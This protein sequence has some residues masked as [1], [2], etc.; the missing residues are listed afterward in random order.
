[1]TRVT[2][3]SDQ[4]S[5]QVSGQI[6]GMC[7][8]TGNTITGIDHVRQC[9]TRIIL[10]RIGT[11]TQRRAFGSD[12][13]KFVSAAGNEATRLKLITVI[14]QSVLKWEPRV[15]LT[16]VLFNLDMDGQCKIELIG[17]YDGQSLNHQVQILGIAA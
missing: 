17:S 5:G 7:E 1:M 6:T 12:F 4:V 3:I 13:F 2:P 10:T 8:N 9:L 15:K 14:A 11:R 16:R